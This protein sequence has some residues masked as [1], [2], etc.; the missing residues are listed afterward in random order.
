VTLRRMP[1]DMERTI[2]DVRAAGLPDAEEFIGKYLLEPW[3]ADQASTFFE[4]LAEGAK[5]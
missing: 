5:R 1:Y 4:S 3:G 2:A